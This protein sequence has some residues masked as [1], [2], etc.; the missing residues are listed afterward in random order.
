MSSSPATGP[1]V[2]KKCEMSPTWK[3][4]S[5]TTAKRKTKDGFLKP[6]KARQHRTTVNWV[7]VVCIA[8]VLWLVRIFHRLANGFGLFKVHIDWFNNLNYFQLSSTNMFRWTGNVLWRTKCTRSKTNVRNSTN[9][10]MHWRL[11]IDGEWPPRQWEIPRKNCTPCCSGFVVREVLMIHVGGTRDV[12]WSIDQSIQIHLGCWIDPSNFFFMVFFVFLDVWLTMMSMITTHA[13]FRFDVQVARV[14]PPTQCFVKAKSRSVARPGRV[15][16]P[17]L[18]WWCCGGAR[19][20]NNVQV[21][22]EFLRIPW[23]FMRFSVVYLLTQ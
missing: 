22:F 19:K 8:W 4:G 17:R 23:G 20:R 18:V 2:S 1:V 5:K 10:S 12:T 3:N 21:S 14:P 13:L 16:C 15:P 7:P 9:A 6:V 11:C